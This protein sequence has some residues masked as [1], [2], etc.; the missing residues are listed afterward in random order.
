MCNRNRTHA[1]FFYF[2]YFSEKSF[3]Q[4]GHP[5]GSVVVVVVDSHIQRIV[6]A[7]KDTTVT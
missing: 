2:D 6:L 4:A 1:H 5:G 3:S 7:T